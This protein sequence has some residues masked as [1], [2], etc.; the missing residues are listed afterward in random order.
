MESRDFYWFKEQVVT[1]FSSKILYLRRHW[2]LMLRFVTNIACFWTF[3][4]L[5]TLV[6]NL[7]PYVLARSLT[8]IGFSS[9]A[10]LNKKVRWLKTST[11]VL[12]REIGK[13]FYGKQKV[14]I[15]FGQ[16]TI[17]VFSWF[18]SCFLMVLFMFSHAMTACFSCFFHVFTCFLMFYKNTQNRE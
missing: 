17:H 11:Y 4:L 3:G 2:Y 18:S 13:T 12:Q 5:R 15:Y 9:I 16:N 14:L 1:C 6:W 7:P 8:S 10:E